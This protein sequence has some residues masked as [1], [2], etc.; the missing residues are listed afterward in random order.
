MECRIE[1][2]QNDP[3]WTPSLGEKLGMIHYRSGH[4]HAE[5]D[6]QTGTCKLHYD[7]DDPHESPTSLV[8]HM[9]ESNLGIAVLVVGALAILDEIFNGG[10]LRK[11]VKKSIFE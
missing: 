1:D 9:G 3:T 10:N 11:E 6:P 4:W 5:C 8:K 7:K 2:I